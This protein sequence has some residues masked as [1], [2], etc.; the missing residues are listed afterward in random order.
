MIIVLKSVY[1][2]GIIIFMDKMELDKKMLQL[3]QGDEQAF[4]DIYN[5]TKRGLFA[6]IL[7]ICRNYHTAEDMMQ[8]AYIKLRTTIGSY[9]AGS[10]AYAWLYTIAKNAT[11]NEL[12]K[13]SR[14][15]ATDMQDGLAKYGTYTMDEDGSPVTQVM[16]KV[17]NE[18]ERQIVSL[19]AISGFKHREIAE[20]LEKP[21]G[22]VLW[23]YNNAL[24]KIKKQL[25]K[26]AHDEA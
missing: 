26:E 14:E 9:K 3:Q 10:N 5:D 23:A 13:Q 7:S 12:A 20:M 16:N 17:L 24:A 21:L 8:T 6:F 4:E 11:L 25:E 2:Y 15:T 18:T 19:H 22:S 1:T